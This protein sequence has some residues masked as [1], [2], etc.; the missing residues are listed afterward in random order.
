MP[1]ML[2]KEMTSEATL[3]S[4]P[5]PQTPSVGPAETD[6]LVT[7]ACIWFVL[8]CFRH[9]ELGWTFHLGVTMT[10]DRACFLLLVGTFVAQVLGGR[11]RIARPGFTGVC[12]L[13]FAGVCFSS[14]VIHD[15]DA[16][17]PTGLRWLTTLVNMVVYPF[18]AYFVFKSTPYDA[19]NLKRMLNWVTALGAYLAL[20][21]VF[22]HYEMTPLVWPQYI[23]DPRVG[24]Q[25][26]RARGPFVSAIELGPILILAFLVITARSLHSS[27]PS[28]LVLIALSVIS[29]A[30]IYFTYTR[31]VWLGLMGSLVLSA[32]FSRGFRRISLPVMGLLLLVFLVGI[33][34][35]LSISSGTL[36][37]RRQNTID[38]RL[39]NYEIAFLVFQQHPLFGVGYGKFAGTDELRE[40]HE[41]LRSG[42]GAVLDDGNHNTFLGLLAETGLAGF[43]TYLLTLFGVGAISLGT[44][45]RLKRANRLEREVAVL[46]VCLLFLF[47]L[48]G[49]TGDLR[50]HVAV[51][52]MAFSIF[53]I[54]AAMSRDPRLIPPPERAPHRR[55]AWEIL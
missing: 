49:Q 25:W 14:Y 20:T 29:L 52:G 48:I 16:E 27:G 13:M 10:P 33:A 7:I 9:E 41:K 4:P 43:S 53:G 36:F 21:A 22:E 31:S 24:I 12:M 42:S 17:S 40:F 28:R 2:A 55:A 18:V 35:K 23:M 39:L 37:S 5:L 3:R 47:F 38:Y 50:F 34:G 11:K 8:L 26:G 6:R 1:V 45:K 54:I 30:A 15:S 19:A 51:H 44:L 46:A 32:V